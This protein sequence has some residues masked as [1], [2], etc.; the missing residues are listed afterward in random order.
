MP[1]FAV[2]Q[3]WLLNSAVALTFPRLMGAL[4]PQGAFGLYA[5][6]NIIGWVRTSEWMLLILT[7]D[8]N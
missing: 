3:T 8:P 5:G 1:A 6:F 7:R 2:A 4:Q